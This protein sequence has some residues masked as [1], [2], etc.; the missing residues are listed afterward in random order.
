[1][2]MELLSY[3]LSR[4]E[5]YFIICIYRTRVLRSTCVS[6]RAWKSPA[7]VIRTCVHAMREGWGGGEGEVRVRVRV[8]TKA[9]ASEEGRR[10]REMCEEKMNFVG[11]IR[12]PCVWV[13][14]DEWRGA[15]KRG[16][17]RRYA[18]LSFALHLVSRLAS[19]GRAFGQR[20]D[21]FCWRRYEILIL[22]V[23]Q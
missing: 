14:R 6:A 10:N 5:I 4:L 12:A 9:W 19:A 16:I 20:R 22:F 1:M 21:W 17:R 8:A 11:K 23:G 15:A 13:T 3:I 2:E 18:P 7:R